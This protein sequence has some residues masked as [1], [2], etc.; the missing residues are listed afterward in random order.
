MRGG[1]S[2]AGA[3]AMLGSLST[4]TSESEGVLPGLRVGG[5]VAKARKRDC[6]TGLLMWVNVWFQDQAEEAPRKKLKKECPEA[7]DETRSEEYQGPAGRAALWTLT[8]LP[9][10]GG[11]PA[12]LWEEILLLWVWNRA[13]T[14]P[15]EVKES[16]GREVRQV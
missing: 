7:S 10:A 8:V 6:L 14:N 5:K 4:G 16:L 1:P 13:S 3:R 2:L 12:P 9:R 15:P 11:G